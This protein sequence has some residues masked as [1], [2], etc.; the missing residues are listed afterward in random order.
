MT[1]ATPAAAIESRLR[2]GWSTAPI[3]LSTDIENLPDTP[4]AFVV[5]EFPGAI[6]G[7]ITIGVPGSNTFREEG[8]FLVHVHVP[9]VNEVGQGTGAG[10]LARTYCEQIAALYRGQQL[11]GVSCHAP[12]PPQETK[13]VNGNYV[14][15]SFSV[16]YQWDLLA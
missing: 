11:G 10:T 8:A 16:P 6:A 13:P 1:S 7:Q 9:Q 2:A 12:H 4:A 14:R 5:L 15:L 3:Y